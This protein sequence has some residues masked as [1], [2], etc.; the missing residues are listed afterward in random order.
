MGG[1]CCCKFDLAGHRLYLSTPELAYLIE[2][3]PPSMQSARRLRCP[4]QIGPRCM[5][6]QRRSLGCRVFFCDE[7]LTLATQRLYEE[8]HEDI[9][10]LAKA[11]ELPYRY[12]ELTGVL[13]QLFDSP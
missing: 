8:A 1:G 7:K 13:L 2:Q 9:R 11:L 3:P 5:A 4:Y 10:N 6:R 12:A